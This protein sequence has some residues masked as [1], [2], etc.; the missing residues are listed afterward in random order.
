MSTPAGAITSIAL[1]LKRVERR[2]Q[3]S[4]RVSIQNKLQLALRDITFDA[5]P[6]SDVRY[7]EPRLRSAGQ[8]GAAGSAGAPQI[9]I[10]PL[11]SIAPDRLLG[12]AR[13]RVGMFTHL[14]RRFYFLLAKLSLRHCGEWQG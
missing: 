14:R 10:G 6:F 4:L 1:A 5:R 7:S 13:C 9:A 3:K 11:L 8:A 12:L 2:Q